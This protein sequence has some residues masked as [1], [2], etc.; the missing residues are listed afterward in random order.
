LL[1]VTKPDPETQTRDLLSQLFLVT[2]SSETFESPDYFLR[3][4]LKLFYLSGFLPFWWIFSTN[5]FF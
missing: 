4:G 3:C 1:L 2:F 5:F